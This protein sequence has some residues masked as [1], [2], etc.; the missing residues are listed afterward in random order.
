MRNLLNSINQ[1]KHVQKKAQ[2]YRD[3]IR[4]E[5]KIGGEVFGPIPKGRRRE[6]FCLDQYTWVWHEEYYN[7]SGKLES[8]ITRY[9]VRKDH[10]LKV[11]DGR[12]YHIDNEEA[13]RLHQ[14]IKTY[15]KN[16]KTQLY[17]N[18]A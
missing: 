10:I 1:Q 6:F 11:Q 14:A 12:Y 8:K 15:V 7:E 5:A 13:L 4:R 17:P 18:F 3:L 9:E 2:L 16:V